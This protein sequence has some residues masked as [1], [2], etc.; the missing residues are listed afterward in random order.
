MVEESQS[1]VVSDQIALEISEPLE[2][3]KENSREIEVE[4]FVVRYPESTDLKLLTL[5]Y[6]AGYD[7]FHKAAVLCKLLRK[8]L[9]KSGLLDQT[10][11]ITIKAPTGDYPD[12]LPVNS[13]KYAIELADQIQIQVN[14]NNLKYAKSIFNLIELAWVCISKINK[15]KLDVVVSLRNRLKT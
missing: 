13:F 14:A 7:L 10:K 8:E 15:I 6:L 2:E 12:Y 4:G 11:V 1:Q 3:Q 9:P 5:S